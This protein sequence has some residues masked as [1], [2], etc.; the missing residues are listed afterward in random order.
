MKNILTD[1][2]ESCLFHYRKF[3]LLLIDR[4][5]TRKNKRIISSTYIFSYELLGFIKW[6]EVTRKYNCPVS[7]QKR[8]QT[9][10]LKNIKEEL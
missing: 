7:L 10:L 4:I 2:V 5:D 6:F 8:I 9:E 1:V 3:N